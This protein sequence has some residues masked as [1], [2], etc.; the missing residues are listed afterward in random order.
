[1]P[2]KTKPRLSLRAFKSRFDTDEKCREF[3][4]HAVW[5]DAPACR[6]CGSL[7]LWRIRGKSARLGLFECGERGCGKQFT[8][9]VGTVFHD[10]HL[11]LTKWFLAIYLLAET[12]KG[13]LADGSRTRSASPTRRRGTSATASA[14]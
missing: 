12:S 7:K 9:T 8:V 13:V 4:E 5:G 6:H 2:A 14:A 11:P 10:T 3:L 1:M